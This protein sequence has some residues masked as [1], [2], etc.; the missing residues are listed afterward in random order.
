MSNSLIQDVFNDFGKIVQKI[1]KHT[2][3]K[4]IGYLTIPIIIGFFIL[5]KVNRNEASIIF[6]LRN[7]IN[8]CINELEQKI[9]NITKHDSYLIYFEKNEFSCHAFEFIGGLKSIKKQKYFPNNVINLASEAQEKTNKL[10]DK[11]NHYNE[12]FITREKKEYAELFKKGNIV[13]DDDQQS[14]V[15]TDD[16]HN[17]VIAGA[18]SG[19]TE[20]LTTR[21]AYITK[22]KSGTVKPERILA[23][24]FQNK[25]ALEIKERLK[26]RYG[27]D[28]EVRTFH[29]LGWKIITEAY[30]SNGVKAPKLKEECSNDLEYQEYIQNLY[31]RE[32]K[33]KDL[34]D[35]IIPFMENFGDNEIIKAKK[36]F[37][38]KKEYYEYQSKLTYTALNGKKVKSKS[39]KEILNFFL[40]HNL[41]GNKI[42]IVYEKPAHWMK[43][44]DKNGNV[45]IKSVDKGMEVVGIDGLCSYGQYGDEEHFRM[46]KLNQYK[47]EEKEDKNFSLNSLN[48]VMVTK[49]DGKVYE[50]EKEKVF[51]TTLP[52]DKPLEIIDLYDLRSLIENTTFRELKQGWLINKIP[53]KTESAVTTHILLTLSM[54]SLTNAYRSERGILITQ[55]GI[56]SYRIKTFAQTKDKVIIIA[57]PYYAIFDL[58]ELMVLV[59]KPP[60]EFF[61]IDPEKFKREYGLL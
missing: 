49:W 51:I 50:P 7:S 46:Y 8:E 25:A 32:I 61:N 22:R 17:L 58:E 26:K 16:K 5:R 57:E 40:K 12:E 43:Y 28:V 37:K 1:L 19:K 38:K 2:K 20:V 34:Q 53:K 47:K 44:V 48:V 13:F 10:L 60:Q 59:G 18:G 52:I 29:S 21:I 33:E 42:D 55:K 23:L 36:D 27:L 31:N 6:N 24:A 11:I 30:K 35:K 15:I 14:A 4:F 54:F 45:K 56:R 41:N 9:Q 3:L 39:E